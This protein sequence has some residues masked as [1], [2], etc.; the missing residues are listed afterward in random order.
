ML[1]R[2]DEEEVS[3]L[4]LDYLKKKKL[5]KSFVSLERELSVRLES[6][7]KEVEYFKSLVLSGKLDEA[8]DFLKLF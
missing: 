1:I 7:S 3:L 4:I 2:V 6:Y 8:V 5:F